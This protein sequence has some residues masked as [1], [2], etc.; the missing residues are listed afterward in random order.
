[1]NTT[2]LHIERLLRE[3]GIVAVPGLG[4]F[5]SRRISSTLTDGSLSAPSQGF[6]FEHYS[7]NL[8]DEELCAS[9]ARALECD[10]THAA[11]VLSED[12]EAIRRELAIDG[13]SAIGDCGMLKAEGTQVSFTSADSNA[14]LKALALEPLSDVTVQE[15]IDRAAEERR[16]TFMRSLRRTASSAAAIAVFAVLA[17]VFS[18]LPGRKAGDPQVASMGFEQPALPVQPIMPGGQ[19]EPS[20]VLIFNTPA[21]ASCPVESEPVVIAQLPKEDKSK[22]CLVVASLASMADAQEY[23]NTYGEGYKILEKDG[24]YR[25]YTLS[26]ESFDSLNRAAIEAGEYTRHPNAWICRR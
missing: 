19:A 18:Q 13:N 22:Y 5:V 17:F 3:R 6:S 24:R 20:L 8:A 10:T 21:D 7:G 16:E 25:I 9:L 15:N 23:V 12:V 11:N 14:W 2:K 26:G 1:M 4:T